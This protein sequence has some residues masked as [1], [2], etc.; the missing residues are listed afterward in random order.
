L[1]K[2]TGVLVL[3]RPSEEGVYF[4]LYPTLKAKLKTPNSLISF[5]LPLSP[6][7]SFHTQELTIT[8][9]LMSKG[10]KGDVPICS[11]VLNKYIEQ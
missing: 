6:K 8:S 3:A 11:H 4:I 10:N 7:L 5:N 9:E 1:Y 2:G